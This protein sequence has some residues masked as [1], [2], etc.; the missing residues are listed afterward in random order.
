MSAFDS[1]IL[2]DSASSGRLP[3]ILGT[4]DGQRIKYGLEV[5]SFRGAEKRTTNHPYTVIECLIGV[6]THPE[7]TMQEGQK[8]SIG[9]FFNPTWPDIFSRDNAAFLESVGFKNSDEDLK[10]ES[11]KKSF[12]EEQPLVGKRFA[13]EVYRHVRKGEAVTEDDTHADSFYKVEF[14]AIPDAD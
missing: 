7:P 5:L 2:S 14:S 1:I 8:V 11:F 10:P 4:P 12:G 3:K 13:V 9:M 6:S